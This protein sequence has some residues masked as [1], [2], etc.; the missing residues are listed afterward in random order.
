MEKNVNEYNLFNWLDVIIVLELMI[1][2][3]IMIFVVVG[4]GLIIVVFCKN[5]VL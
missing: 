1:V 5:K 2:V 3:L 4:N